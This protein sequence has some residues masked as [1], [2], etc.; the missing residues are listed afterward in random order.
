EYG[1]P[2]YGKIGAY[3][4]SHP[5]QQQAVLYVTDR[6]HISTKHLP[7]VWTRKDEWYNFKDVSK[8]IKVLITIDEKSYTGGI[9]GEVHPMAWYHKYDGGRSW[10]TEL[11]H[12]EESYADQNY[13]QHL[14]G[15]IQY[16]IKINLILRFNL[17]YGLSKEI[18]NWI[19]FITL[20]IDF[21]DLE[22]SSCP[23][24]IN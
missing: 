10:Y 5:A 12:T 6:S 8:D 3:F 11:G 15:G 21:T 16:A 13:L 24:Q 20:L 14:L 18:R 22:L 9:N 7:A 4:V 1:W 23:A 19:Y 17:S 2:W